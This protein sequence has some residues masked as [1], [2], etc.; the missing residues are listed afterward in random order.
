MSDDPT[1]RH[2]ILMEAVNVAL[3]DMQRALVNL[4]VK[5]GVLSQDAICEELRQSADD[6]SAIDDTTFRLL[7]SNLGCSDIPDRDA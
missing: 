4:I 1:L 6:A 5:K 2:A 7:M 3:W